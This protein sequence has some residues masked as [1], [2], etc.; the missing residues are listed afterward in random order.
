MITIIHHL[1]MIVKEREP[2]PKTVAD[3]RFGDRHR[4]RQKAD[5]RGEKPADVERAVVLIMKQIEVGRTRMIAGTDLVCGL[6]AL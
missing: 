5:S 4:N 6:H 1:R 2:Q 3:R